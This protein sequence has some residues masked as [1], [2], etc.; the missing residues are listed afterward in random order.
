MSF[1][2]R[3]LPEI[4]DLVIAT[5]N[6]VFDKGAYVTLDEYSDVS[7]Y[8][9]IGE[10]SSTWVHNIRDF[11]KE[12]RKVVLKVIRVDKG[13]RYVDLSL[14]RV[15]DREKRDKL[16]EWKRFNR[17]EKLLELLSKRMGEDLDHVHS[18]IAKKLIDSFG[19]VLAGFEEAAR[20]GA[21]PLVNAGIPSDVAE[22]IVDLAKE[23]IELKE[24][25]VSAIIQLNSNASDGVLRIIE[26]LNAAYE[27]IRSFGNVK[28]RIYSIGA[29]RYRIDVSARDYHVAE[30]AL[31]K[32]LDSALDRISSLGGSGSFKR[33]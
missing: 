24:S 10:V 27:S 4:G 16:L 21:A 26:A 17:G 20:F 11:L 28:C 32:A 12:G 6:E 23:S 25:R 14:R 3:D 33:V 8:V 30:E 1:K 18:T 19:D 13:K 22:I 29:P 2:R 15:S 9:P 5:V 7:G 31:K